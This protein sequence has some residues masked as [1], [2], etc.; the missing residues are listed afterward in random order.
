MAVPPDGLRVEVEKC[1]ITWAHARLDIEELHRLNTPG[2]MVALVL[3]VR[4][5]IIGETAPAVMASLEEAME[6]EATD[7]RPIVEAINTAVRQRNLRCGY[8]AATDVTLDTGGEEREPP[9]LRDLSNSLGV[10][11]EVTWFGRRAF[12]RLLHMQSTGAMHAIQL[13]QRIYTA[14]ESIAAVMQSVTDEDLPGLF[15]ALDSALTDYPQTQK[16][17]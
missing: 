9:S 14:G 11:L 13:T 4:I 15:T 12:D 5:M 16:H 8:E 7:A 17:K 3:I 6:G 2:A 10:Y 1:L